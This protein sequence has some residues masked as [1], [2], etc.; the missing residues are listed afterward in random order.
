[1]STL[2][3]D[4]ISAIPKKDLNIYTKSGYGRR[5]KLGKKPALVV[6]D[7]TYAFTGDR[8]EPILKSIKRFPNSCGQN[9]WRSIPK[10]KQ[11]LELCREKQV[12]IFYTANGSKKSSDAGRWRN[13]NQNTAESDFIKLS[14]PESIV[15]E[16]APTSEDTVIPRLK[17]STFFRTNFHKM[18][19]SKNIDTL[20]V[21]GGT[22]S[23]CVR[24]TVVDAFS[25]NLSVGV[26]EECVFD[27]GEVSHN[28]NLFD[29]DSKYANVITLSE[30][31]SY[32]NSL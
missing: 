20:L 6:I 29:M 12:P 8:S 19:Q 21:S 11:I 3:S 7:V 24:A 5:L 30:A 28:V 10:I 1:V 23:G 4:W 9:A 17:P 13:K 18:M 14:S 2:H 27:R 15:S 32:L 31:K 22:T 25:Y 16:I 26:I